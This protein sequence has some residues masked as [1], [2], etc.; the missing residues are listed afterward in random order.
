MKRK[1]QGKYKGLNLR[2]P[3][4]PNAQLLSYQLTGTELGGVHRSTVHGLIKAGELDQVEIGAR[5]FVT[6][7]S[8]KNL[9]AR[10][11]RQRSKKTAD[12]GCG[13][14]ANAAAE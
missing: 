4:D 3:P 1:R 6:R 13:A 5:R 10:R 7:D 8:V 11:L 14:I 9:I 2:P 12:A